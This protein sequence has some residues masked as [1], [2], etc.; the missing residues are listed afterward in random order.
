MR[1]DAL[2]VLIDARMLIGRFS[3][4]ARVVTRLVDELTRCPRLRVV[5]LCGDQPYPPWIERRDMELVIT[6]FRRRD[7]VATRRAIWEERRLPAIIRRAGVDLF[8]ATW[9]TGIPWR[10]PVPS[11]LTIHDLIPW[12]DA[13]GGYRGLLQR[14]TYRHAM[15]ASLRR[16][17]RITVV[18]DVVRRQ[19]VSLLGV[20]PDRMTVV[21]NGV[22]AA[23]Y[24][25]PA[26]DPLSPG[27][28]L[29]IGG[30]E[31]RKN[32]EAILE[33]LMQYWQ[34]FDP[35]LELRLTG[36]PQALS[37]QAAACFRRL[38]PQAPIRFLGTLADHELSRQYASARALL[39]LSREEGFGLPALEAMAWGCPAI[40]AN[41]TS[42]PEI[43]GDAGVLVEADDP[44]GVATALHQVISS[45]A[46]RA[47]LIRRG[48]ERARSFTWAR[49]AAEYVRAYESALGVAAKGAADWPATSPV[50][51]PL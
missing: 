45:P 42:L 11:V 15:R 21:H 10:C 12:S 26:P 46:N 24:R 31:P 9:N 14:Y 41:R 44:V 22:D 16:A 23:P 2:R 33:A 49:A 39:L 18:S 13:G 17:A 29:Y 43:V 5:A 7:R 50:P 3:G 28:V 51:G 32:V 35:R 4:V 27:Y 34:R 6:D 37:P 20:A 8:H 1:P 19:M 47:Q 38:P 36:D 48:T 40:V 30:H 25:S